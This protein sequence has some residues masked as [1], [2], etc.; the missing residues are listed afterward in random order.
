VEI[1]CVGLN[2][3][4]HTSESSF[5]VP[6]APLL[7]GKF[8]N[9]LVGDGEPILVSSSLAHVDAEAELAVVIGRRAKGVGVDDA[10]EFVHGYTVANDVSARELQFGDGQWFRGK[11]LDGFCPLLSEIVPVADLGEASGLRVVQRLNGDV[12]QDGNT[13]N[14]IFGVRELVAY[15]SCNITLDPGDVVLTGTPDGVG[16]FREPKVTL[17]PGDRVSVSIAALYHVSG[18]PESGVRTLGPVARRDQMGA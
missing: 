9:T 15:I 8:A 11:G 17:S 2:Y 10:L 14:L 12:L 16:Y 5:T 6:A 3:A 18:F 4:S 7:F 13:S 1:V